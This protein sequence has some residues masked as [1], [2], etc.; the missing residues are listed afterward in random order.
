MAGEPTGKRIAIVATDGF[1]RSELIEP[2]DA[3]R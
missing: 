1:D 2:R 3:L